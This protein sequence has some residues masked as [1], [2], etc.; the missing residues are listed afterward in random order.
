LKSVENKIHLVVADRHPVTTHEGRSLGRHPAFER[1]RLQ[2]SATALVVLMLSLARVA[3][4]QAPAPLP[5]LYETLPQGFEVNRGQAD[6]RFAFVSHGP[7]YAVLLAAD[8]AE[9]RL[10]AGADLPARGRAAAL[11][12]RLLGAN[13]RARAEARDLQPGRSNYFIGNRPGGWQTDVPRYGRA[14]FHQVYPGIDIA[15]YGSQQQLEYDWVVRAGADPGRIRLGIEGADGVRIDPSGDLVLALG[16]A[17][18]RQRKPI[19]YQDMP[20]GRQRIECRYVMRGRYQVGLEVAGYDRRRQL[21]IDPTLVFSTYY[22]GNGTDSGRAIKVDAAGNIYVGGITGSTNLADSPL[23]H[24]FNTS[25]SPSSAGLI[26]KISPSGT[27]VFAAYIAGTKDSAGA[28]GLAIDKDGN[29]YLAGNTSATDFPTLNPI[30][31]AYGGGPA[32]AFVVE[33]STSGNSL[34]YSTYLG[35]PGGDFARA[36]QVDDSGNAYVT[37]SAQRGFP[38]LN[39][40]QPTYGGGNIN[41]FAAKIAPGGSLLYCTYLGGNGYDYANGVATDTS[42]DLIAYGDTSSTDFPVL[43]AFQ[44]KPHGGGDGWFA[45]L[46]PDGTLIYASYI[47]GSSGDAVRGAQVDALGDLYLAGDTSSTDFPTLNPIQPDYG[48]GTLD[49]WVVELNPAASALIFSTYWG[50]SGSDSILDLELDPLGNV[51]L[52]GYTS[53][54]D[55]PTV[56]PTQRSYGGGLCG[57]SH[58]PCTDAF[59]TKMNPGG[60]TVFFSTYLGGNTNDTAA[61]MAVD[62]EGRAYL[63]G[64]TSGDFPTV[65]PLQPAYGGGSSNAFVA[66]LETCDFTLV[67]PNASFGLG[68]GNAS[69]AINTTPECGWTASSNDSWITLTSAASGVGSGSVSYSVASSTGGSE[70]TGTIT[71]GTQAFSVTQ[72]SSAPSVAVAPPSLGFGVQVLNTTS[73][74]RTVTL[75][76]SGSAQL[77][78]S[79]AAVSGPNA[80]DFVISADTCTG[81]PVAPNGTCTVSVAFTPSAPGN[82]SG[83]LNFTDNATGNPQTVPLTGTAPLLVITASS[84]SMTY[85]GTVPTI[86]PSYSG[87]VNGDTSAS[88]TTPPTCTTTA[89]SQSLAGSYPSS[90]TGAVDSNYTITYVNGTV[91][92]SAAALA[93]TASNATMTYGGTVPTI[94]PSY[95]GFVNGDTSASLTTQPTCSTTATSHGPTGSYPSSCS[96]AVDTNYNISYVNGT[97]TDSAAALAITASNASMTYG[98][99]APTITPSYS[100]FVNGDTSASLTTPPT[101]STT[102]TAHSAAGSYPSSCSGAV[103]SNYTISYVNGTVTDSA[104]ALAITASSASMTYGGTVPAITPSYSG[105]VSGDTAAS[106]T[107]QPT[108]STTATS[109]SPAGSYPS[110]CSGAV[111]SNYT[112]SYVNGTVTDSVGTLAITASSA[113]MTYGGATPV[114]TPSYSGFVNGDTSASLTT[115]PTCSTTATAH[116]AAGSY[117]SSCSGAVDSNY[118]ISYVN[119]TVTESA[120]ALTITASSGSMTYGGTVPTITPSYS[121]FVN[122]DTSASLT[123]APT[124]STTATGSTPVGTDAGADT[125]SGAVGPNYSFTYVAA[126]VTVNEATPVI[127]WPMPAAITHGTM[128][129]STQLDATASVPGTLV[130]SPAAGTTPAAGTDTLSVTFTPTD[131]AD[132]STATA[133]VTLAVADF[134]FTAP[135]GSSASATVAPGQPATYTLSVGGEGGLSGMVTFTCTGAPSETTCTVSPNPATAGSSATNVTVTVSTTAPSVSVPHSRPLPPVAPLSP[136]LKDLFMLALLLA[137][138][139]WAIGRRDRYGVSRWPSAVVLL[140]SGLLLTLALAGCGGGG[141]GGGGPAPNPGTPAG[142]YMLTVTGSTGSGSATLSHSVTLTLNVN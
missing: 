88:L 32:D 113:S 24:A 51:Y 90:C 8:Q 116:S 21:V 89:T 49:A 125:C 71:L 130:Y 103:G 137:A 18:V 53:S 31:S 12:V 74:S 73:G 81:A 72:S 105:F 29:A 13:R 27:L 84:A 101:C 104:A 76:N 109:H 82:R 79:A 85:G 80:G 134:T 142:T 25:G 124:C 45:K 14:G 47:G 46:G 140:A 15:Y 117:P 102:A 66:I 61:G 98:G 107:T 127:T 54:A 5:R 30:Q 96:G 20:G 10:V 93:I 106:L 108:C 2:L 115:P 52:A 37:G 77:S 63:A 135:P 48:G 112:I 126:N 94:T 62:A 132:Y 136:A 4:S 75:S 114:I 58:T 129:S 121:G 23:G 35:G 1:A 39:A 131:T 22:G 91:T 26:A 118:T 110:S 43:N 56:N 123:T 40:E 100:G 19:A 41:A 83:S 44:S 67:P 133:T 28:T 122:G 78:I 55:F 139:A 87:F 65:D 6:P 138:M 42:G 16:A 60:S 59:L 86:T 57:S 38:L 7:G 92:D 33:V 128:L 141:G 17:A 111:D 70:Q 95:S 97:V 34:V 9:M 11:R 99:T 69:V 119:G 64:Y 120:A 50:G 68:G 3:W 36:I